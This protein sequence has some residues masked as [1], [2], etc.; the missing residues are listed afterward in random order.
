MR[1]LLTSVLALFFCINIAFA[2]SIESSFLMTESQDGRQTEDL[3]EVWS[4]RANLESPNP[5]VQIQAASFVTYKGE[6]SLF[7]WLHESSSVAQ[8]KPDV[9]KI[10]LNGRLNPFSGLEVVL[11]LSPD[12]KKIQTISG[13]MRAGTRGQSVAVFKPDHQTQNKKLLLTNPSYSYGSK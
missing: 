11:E 4:V 6:T 12:R 2:E 5:T 10:E 9:Y 3:F 8:V 7:T 13:S 1:K